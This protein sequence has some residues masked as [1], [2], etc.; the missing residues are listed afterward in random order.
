MAFSRKHIDDIYI[1][2]EK[3][4]GIEPTTLRKLSKLK[5]WRSFLAI[6]LDW[7]VIVVCIVA[8]ETISYWL[9]PMAF[10]IIG[11]RFHALEAMMHEAT[12]FRLHPNKTINEITGEL[13]VW[14]LGLSVFLYRY[15]RHFSHHKNIGTEKDSHVFQSYKKH[16]DLFRV[17]FTPLRLL[18]NCLVAACQFPRELWLGQIYSCVKL[19]PAIS[20]KVAIL[21]IGLQLVALLFIIAASLMWGLKVVAIYA[22]FFVIPFVWV[23]IF[24][25]YLRLLSE[26][27]G[28][29]S[30]QQNAVAGAGTRT[31][32]VSW[33]VR[34]MLWPHHLNYHIEHHWYPSVPFYNL[35]ALHKVL[36]E[37]PEIRRK[38]HVTIGLKNLVG[39][40]TFSGKK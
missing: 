25:R 11:T 19:L 32:L 26:H 21:W 13:A 37:S 33:P 1:E 18:K 5:P 17:P 39:E 15:L 16:P 36:Y 4:P 10:V 34:V 28:I 29:P 3:I 12:H 35:P 30:A 22:M 27:F 9:Y 38:M 31:V 8:C 6:A 40:L 20:G 7:S 24:S 2:Q 14:P 23:A